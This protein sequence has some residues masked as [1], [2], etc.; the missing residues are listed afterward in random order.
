MALLRGSS[1]GQRARPL[2]SVHWCPPLVFYPLLAMCA[3]GNSDT[4][5]ETVVM[6]LPDSARLLSPDA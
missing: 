5:F 4:S 3:D 6:T 2:R 1:W